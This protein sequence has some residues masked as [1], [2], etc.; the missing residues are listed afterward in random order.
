MDRSAAIDQYRAALNSPGGE[1]PE[2]KGAAQRGLDQPYEP[3]QKKD[4]Q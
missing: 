3:P 1:L 2:V 4:Q